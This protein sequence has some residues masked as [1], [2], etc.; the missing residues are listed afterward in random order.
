MWLNFSTESRNKLPQPHAKQKQGRCDAMHIAVVK[1]LCLCWPTV[2]KKELEI[3]IGQLKYLQLNYGFAITSMALC[4]VALGGEEKALRC[5]AL[6]HPFPSLNNTTLYS[7]LAFLT[8]SLSVSVSMRLRMRNNNGIAH[9]TC[10][11]HTSQQA[12]HCRF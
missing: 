9:C 8:K 7:R 1:R 10:H 12:N 6:R 4:C 5:A 11:T 3:R 2:R